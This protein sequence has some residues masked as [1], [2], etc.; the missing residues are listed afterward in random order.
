MPGSYSPKAGSAARPASAA[1]PEQGDVRQW[2]GLDD[3]NGTYYRKDYTLMGVGDHIEVWVANDIAFPAGDCRAQV[4]GTT[5]VTQAQVDALVT[6]FDTNIYP[7]E[8][9]AFSVGAVPDGT[10]AVV[11]PDATARRRLHRPRQ[12]YLHPVDN[13]RDDTTHFPEGRLTSRASSRAAQL[14][15]A[16]TS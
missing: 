9:A 2:L 5:E 10:N 14:T 4:P 12:Q 3:F 11:G 15:L 13:V 1:A 7:K 16:A 8:S 6:E